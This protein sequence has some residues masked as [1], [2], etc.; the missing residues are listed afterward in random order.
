MIRKEDYERAKALLS[1]MTIEEKLYQLTS[2]MI[3][4]VGEDYEEKRRNI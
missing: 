1:Q 2:Q 3:Y 4:S